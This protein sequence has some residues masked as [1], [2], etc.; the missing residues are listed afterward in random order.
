MPKQILRFTPQKSMADISQAYKHN[1]R[2]EIPVT[3]HIDADRTADNVE[4]I[5]LPEG[6]KTIK[7]AFNKRISEMDYYKTHKIA[8]NAV[9]CDEI[10]LAFGEGGLPEDFSVSKWAENCEKYLVDTFGRENVLSAVVHMDE[11]VPHIHAIVIPEYNGKLSAR[12]I[13]GTRD[14]MRQQ[15]VTFYEN[16]MCEVGLE[17]EDEYQTGFKHGS[18]GKYYS[19]LDKVFEQ[20][21]PEIEPGESH[22]AYYKRV[23]DIYVNQNLQLFHIQHKMMDITQKY[24]ALKYSTKRKEARIRKQYEKELQELRTKLEKVNEQILDR[25]GGSIEQ[26]VEAIEFK[27]HYD[28]VFEHY[29]EVAPDRAKVIKED[30]AEMEKVFME[31]LERGDWDLNIDDDMEMQH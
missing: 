18:F 9:L 17:P 3:E 28:A 2:Q 23:N 15:H 13:H 30:F 24:D 8:K 27:D 12:Q 11:S 26:A 25:L 16:Y 14:K 4:L 6:C 1:T 31:D 21:L 10:V 19:A 22:E 29:S 5:S 7:Q 20:S